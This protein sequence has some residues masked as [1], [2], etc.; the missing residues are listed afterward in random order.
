MT[1]KHDKTYTDRLHFDRLIHG[2]QLSYKGREYDSENPDRATLIEYAPTYDR[3]TNGTPV[4]VDAI[5]S[6]WNRLVEYAL[7]DIAR[8]VPR[9]EAERIQAGLLDE[10]PIVAGEMFAKVQTWAKEHPEVAETYP[11]VR[12]L[13]ATSPALGY[14]TQLY[15]KHHRELGRSSGSIQ[16]EFGDAPYQKESKKKVLKDV[17]RI[18]GPLAKKILSRFTVE[19]LTLTAAENMAVCLG[20]GLIPSLAHSS[21]TYR[22]TVT[23]EDFPQKTTT[24]AAQVAENIRSTLPLVKAMIGVRGARWKEEAPEALRVLA[25]EYVELEW[26]L[27]NSVL[28]QSDLPLLEAVLRQQGH[29]QPIAHTRADYKDTLSWPLLL[30]KLYFEPQRVENQWKELSITPNSFLREPGLWEDPAAAEQLTALAKSL[31]ELYGDEITG[32]PVKYAQAVIQQADQPFGGRGNWNLEKL[33]NEVSLAELAKVDAEAVVRVREGHDSL[34]ESELLRQLGKAAQDWYWKAVLAPLR[35]AMAKAA[36]A[37]D[38]HDR[39]AKLSPGYFKNLFEFLALEQTGEASQAEL[40]ETIGRMRAELGEGAE[41]NRAQDLMTIY[42]KAHYSAS[43]ADDPQWRVQYLVDQGILQESERDNWN[44]SWG[45][46]WPTADYEGAHR[47]RKRAY[48]DQAKDFPTTRE[49]QVFSDLVERD[50]KTEK[51]VDALYKPKLLV[52]VLNPQIEETARLIQAGTDVGPRL[53]ELRHQVMQLAPE[54]NQLRDYFLENLAHLEMWLL[55]QQT[56][57]VGQFVAE[58]IQLDITTIDLERHLGENDRG[59]LAEAYMKSYP[60]IRVKGLGRALFVFSIQEKKVIADFLTDRTQ[61][62]TPATAEL[63]ERLAVELEIDHLREDYAATRERITPTGSHPSAEDRI[64]A[65]DFAF[66]EVLAHVVERFPRATYHRDSILFAIMTDLATTLPQ[67]QQLERLTYAYASRHPAEEQPGK[68]AP[69]VVTETVKN[70]LALFQDRG[71]RRKVLTWFFG[72]DIPDDRF[73]EG[74]T[75]QV[76]EQEKVEAFWSLSIEERRAIFY[77]A[78]LGEHG[79]FELPPVNM[80]QYVKWD[81]LDDSSLAYGMPVTRGK[82]ENKEFFAFL[83]DFYK[84]NLEKVFPDKKKG[85]VFKMALFEVFARYRPARRVELFLAIA[86]RLRELKRSQTELTPGDAIR[87]LLEQVGV[88]GVKAGQV[89]SEQKDM[90]PDDVRS[91]LSSLKDRSNPFNKRGVFTYAQQARLFEA[92]EGQPQLAEIAELEGSASI[93]QVHKAITLEGEALALKVERPS[94]DKNYAEDLEVLQHVVDRFELEGFH[95]PSWIVSEIKQ[96]VEAEMDFGREAKNAELLRSNFVRRAATINL[97]GKEVP[98]STPKVKMVMSKAAG[99]RRRMQIMLE[100]FAK[101]ISI[102]DIS[103][104]QEL[105]RTPGTDEKSIRDTER[106]MRKLRRLNPQEQTELWARYAKVDIEGVQAGMAIDLLYQIAEDG[107]FHAD[108][109]G[110]NVM[111]DATPDQ[112]SVSL[113][114][115]GSTGESKEKQR[116]GEA[117]D[118]RTDF[119]DF[120]MNLLLLKS[121]LGDVDRVAEVIRKYTNTG[122]QNYWQTEVRKALEKS[123]TVGDVFK[124]V[125]AEV[126]RVTEGKLDVDFRYLL[127]A[128]A[129]AGGHLEALRSKITGHVLTSFASMD[130]PGALPPQMVLMQ[131]PEIQKLLP[132]LP[133]MPVLAGMLGALMPSA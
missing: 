63:F 124:E 57:K 47:E 56:S 133:R 90:V 27:E 74:I 31:A 117:V 97:D 4:N 38:A 131:A 70:Y 104:L 72:G 122:D 89:L 3:K 78:L 95:V 44:Q 80:G 52:R 85:K 24:P 68:E 127:K 132:L 33:L 123:E 110:G 8:A 30:H 62:L 128:L 55:L 129:S 28:D 43:T 75:F 76:D 36:A 99:G 20:E 29:L 54:K 83:R 9:A 6:G 25:K 82:P 42:V 115:A 34:P 50:D 48:Q 100:E 86:E 45:Y 81:D 66:G 65:A 23:K 113:I 12:F 92:V 16:F 108:M 59:V 84:L 10:D 2:A 46:Q 35:E 40:L 15:K 109:H 93:K 106:I 49:L 53:T 22:S 96:V 41:V 77:S 111:V 125:L 73:L 112:E 101:G 17:E 19:G 64:A 60:V 69:F 51:M 118:A 11:M 1:A 114:D 26:I 107:D 91:D 18:K 79:L 14:V 32:D 67:A 13:A 116:F 120:G 37:P 94:I 7:L 71:M 98:M 126:L 119:L 87:L 102:S 130:T 103:R 39:L 5:Q 58:G 121:G 105:D 21:E 61:A 88:V